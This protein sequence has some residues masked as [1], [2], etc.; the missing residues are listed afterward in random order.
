MSVGSGLF[1]D[2]KKQ[3]WLRYPYL[4]HRFS[5]IRE[6]ENQIYVKNKACRDSGSIQ[7]RTKGHRTP[8][9]P[10]RHES[11]ENYITLFDVL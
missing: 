10:G 6:H 5:D 4:F 3:P 11:R 8:L 9:A 2:G 1:A 7:A